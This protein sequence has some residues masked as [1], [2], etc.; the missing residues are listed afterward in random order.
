MRSESAPICTPTPLAK[1][2]LVSDLLAMDGGEGDEDEHK[3]NAASPALRG[4]ISNKS[5][6]GKS[7][8]REVGNG[9]A[10][11]SYN[12]EEKVCVPLCLAP[13]LYFAVASLLFDHVY[14]V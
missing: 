2:Q 13:L 1:R 8:D 10:F 5:T 14:Q 9:D 4:V 3:P 12:R 11:S 7:F 6:L